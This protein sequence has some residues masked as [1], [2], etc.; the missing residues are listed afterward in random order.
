MLSVCVAGRRTDCIWGQ[1]QL[2][3][4]SSRSIC[5]AGCVV[6]SLFH[7]SRFFLFIYSCVNRL[8]AETASLPSRMNSVDNKNFEAAVAQLGGVGAPEPGWLIVFVACLSSPLCIVQLEVVF[9]AD[10]VLRGLESSSTRPPPALC[11]SVVL[12]LLS[13]SI[14]GGIKG[15]NMH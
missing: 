11:C 4:C 14:D 10:G 9:F 12:F 6:I 7:F 1:Q 2:R 15:P 3:Q 8:G 13:T 5:S